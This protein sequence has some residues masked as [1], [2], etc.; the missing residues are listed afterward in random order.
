MKMTFSVKGMSCAACSARVE[1]VAAK[2]AGVAQCEVSLL[3]NSMTVDGDFNPQEIVDA[4]AK[5]G[6][7]AAIPNEKN[8]GSARES[9]AI[10][11]R[12]AASAA[13]LLILLFFSMGAMLGIP[14]P[15]FA[16]NPATNG[17]IQAVLCSLVMILNRKFFTSGISGV[18][19]RAPNMDSLVALGASAAYLYSLYEL[20]LCHSAPTRFTHFYFE[21]GAM[22]LVLISIGKLLESRAKGKTTSALQGLAKLAPQTAVRLENGR[23]NQVDISKIKPGDT[24]VIKAGHAI[25]VDGVVTKGSAAVDESMLTGESMPADKKEGDAVCAS[26]VVLSGYIQCRADSVG[27]GTLLAQIIQTVES[28]CAGKA[29]IAR[30]ADKIAG[31]FVPIVIAIA[32]ITAAVWALLSN[33]AE[34]ALTFGISVLVISC[35]CALGLATPVAIMAATAKG[36]KNGIL[37]KSA[38]AIEQLAR[39]RQI[40]LDKT[41]TLTLGHP[42]MTDIIPAQ[43]ISPKSLHAAAA[44]IETPSSHPLARAI[45]NAA[46]EQNIE[47][48]NVKQFENITGKGIRALLNGTPHYAGNADFIAAHADIP[49]NARE[50]AQALALQGKTPI[51]IARDTQYLGMIALA[52]AIRPNA[53]Q[54]IDALKE[55]GVTPFMLTG[56]NEKTAR[57]IARQLH[58]EKTFARLLPT[59]KASIIKDLQK[60]SPTAMAGDGINDAPA[61]TQADVGIAVGSGTDI[62]IDAAQLVL[63]NDDPRTITNAIRLSHKTFAII[64]QNLFWAFFYNAIG[65]P[66]A[67][68]AFSGLGLTLN[69]VFCAAAMGLSSLC[70]VSNALRLNFAPIKEDKTAARQ[71]MATHA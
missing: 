9:R 30:I 23:E 1:K 64:R 28:T 68:G 59:D 58:I 10:Q 18:M 27:N 21:S 51:F 24:V 37:F 44:A 54:T 62:A 15:Q 47:I 25:P 31:I 63:L 5:A 71:H 55:M 13:L 53:V 4:V 39:C 52:D 7:Q 22:I 36:A 38:A 26:T 14:Q 45:I 29:P 12:I 57:A 16:Q 43:D 56:D 40:A 65:I 6:F 34:R 70:V 67:A 2:C 61:L 17:A 8:T 42:V 66:L 50:S 32:A 49:Q 48:R 3:T 33:D 19:R 11:I 69:P 46:K 20:Y 41:G 60:T 35:P